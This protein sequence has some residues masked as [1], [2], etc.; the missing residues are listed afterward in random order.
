MHYGITLLSCL[1]AGWKEETGVSI[2]ETSGER[3]S[4]RALRIGALSRCRLPL[5]AIVLI[6]VSGAAQAH[7]VL[8]TDL[9][10]QD[11]VMAMAGPLGGTLVHRRLDVAFVNLDSTAGR[12]RYGVAFQYGATLATNPNDYLGHEADH[13]SLHIDREIYVGGKASLRLHG[14]WRLA[15]G[16]GALQLRMHDGFMDST[17]RWFFNEPT[18]TGW[19]GSLGLQH[20]LGP[21]QMTMGWQMTRYP[22]QRQDDVTQPTRGAFSRFGVDITTPL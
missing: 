17:R 9:A 10:S 12:L 14:Q 2:M 11:D 7:P 22:G 13:R 5:A 16:A 15:A 1:G 8:S 4:M 19:R 6:V 18:L 21:L 20:P 3:A